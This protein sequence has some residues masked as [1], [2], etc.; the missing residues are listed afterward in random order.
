MRMENAL[1]AP[2]CWTQ[3]VSLHSSE[4][5]SQ[6]KTEITEMVTAGKSDREIL[7]YYIAKYGKRIL[8]EPEG[9]A[10][11]WLHIMPFAVLFFGGVWAAL[12]IRKWRIR[13]QAAS[14]I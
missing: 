4:A 13:S 9:A 11:Y 12:M 2:C 3:R 10:S 8:V 14:G 5:S 6:I 1:M 7:D